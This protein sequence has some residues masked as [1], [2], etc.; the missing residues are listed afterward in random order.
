METEYLNLP[1]EQYIKEVGSMES[2]MENLGYPIL[3]RRQHQIIVIQSQ[4]MEMN[5]LHSKKIDHQVKHVPPFTS[6]TTPFCCVSY[7]LEESLLL[8]K[9]VL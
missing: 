2:N 7:I 6:I 9:L 4:K 3:K 1:M 8:L 5:L